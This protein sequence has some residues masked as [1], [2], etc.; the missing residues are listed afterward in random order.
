MRN[1]DI[2]FA[3]NNVVEIET[4]KHLFTENNI[5]FTI[6]DNRDSSYLFG[7]AEFRVSPEHLEQAKK[8]IYEIGIK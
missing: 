2:A 3:T 5:S 1:W 4:V 8:M 6:V 7:E